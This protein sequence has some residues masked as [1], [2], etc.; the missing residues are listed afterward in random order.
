MICQLTKNGQKWIRIVRSFPDDMLIVAIETPLK[1]LKR[2]SS[3]MERPWNTWEKE[4]WN[5][6]VLM[7]EVANIIRNYLRI[8]SLLAKIRV[9]DAYLAAQA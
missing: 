7:K 1:Q 2:R 4:K 8:R 6:R 3:M 9:Q 5:S